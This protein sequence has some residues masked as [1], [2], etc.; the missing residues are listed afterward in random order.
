MQE[1]KEGV[2]KMLDELPVYGSRLRQIPILRLT[3]GVET[4]NVHM[5]TER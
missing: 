4:E 5:E 3:Y 2:K 1:S